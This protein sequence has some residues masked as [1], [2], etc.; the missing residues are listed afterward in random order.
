MKKKNITVGFISF[1]ML[2]AAS[3]SNAQ[4]LACG[5]GRIDT[6]ALN[7]AKQFGLSNANKPL[8]TNYLIRV[9]FHI[10]RNDDA[11][12]APMTAAQVKTEFATLIPSYTADNVCFLNAGFDY[13]NNSFLNNFFNADNDPTGFFFN[14]YQVP[15]CIN[16]FF[17]QKIGGNNTACNPPCGYGGIA[18]GGIPGT[19]FLVAKGNIGDGATVSH[20]M[21]HC[22]G[23]LHTFENA[24]GLEKI[25]GSNSSTAGDRI[26]DKKAD[27]YVYSGATCYSVSA[28]GCTYN[29]NC[30]DPDGATNFTPPYNNLMGY[31]SG[32]CYPN[33]FL[34]TGS[35][36][37]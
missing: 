9:F 16:V 15:G 12:N 29:G 36:S 7:A 37:M 27:P 3:H 33:K 22:L 26:T 31:W 18:L 6:I 35:L 11:T 17:M 5:N 34:L 2:L 20:E 10:V 13:V 4:I 32:V 1:I 8:V 19:F 30:Q 23:L 25:N 14:P 24:F 21:G 28:N